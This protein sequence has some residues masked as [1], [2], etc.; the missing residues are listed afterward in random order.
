MMTSLKNYFSLKK[1]TKKNKLIKNT[2]HIQFIEKIIKSKDLK[3]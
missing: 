1:N 3:L 2:G